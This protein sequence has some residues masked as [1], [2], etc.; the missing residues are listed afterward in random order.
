MIEEKKKFNKA[1]LVFIIIGVCLVL[2][3]IILPPLMF[4]TPDGEYSI[5]RT[6]NGEEFNI[7]V[8]S[9]VELVKEDTTIKISKNGDTKEYKLVFLRREDDEYI[10]RIVGYKKSTFDEYGSVT[11]KS[12]SGKDLVFTCDDSMSSMANEFK[13]KSGKIILTVFPCFFGVFFVLFGF[14]SNFAK[15]KY[16]NLFKV[17]Q[18]FVAGIMGTDEESSEVQKTTITCEYCRLENDNE[19]AKCEHCGA[20]LIRKK[21]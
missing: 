9:D 3:G 11:I 10:F 19:N 16:K 5:D 7:E 20:P 2:I 12:A 18:D 14:I 4:K 8:E 6:V 17:K 13:N 21:K 15:A 1:S